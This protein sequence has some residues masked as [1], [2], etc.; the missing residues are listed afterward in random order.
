M[1]GS[2][3]TP[4]KVLIV[5][6]HPIVREAL[7][8]RLAKLRD[9]MVCAEAEDMTDAL[10]LIDVHNPDLAIVDISL[11]TS[12]GLDLIK[13]I[14]LRNGQVRMLVWSMHNELLYAER[15]LRAGALGYVTKEQA[16][17]QI[18][19]AIRQVLAGQVYLSKA[20]TERLLHR[21]VG[22]EGEKLAASPVQSLSDRELEIL[23]LISRGVKTTA[24][25]GQLHLSVKTIETYRD[26]IR[27]KLNLPD[28]YS[29]LRF[30]V[31]WDQSSE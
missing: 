14:K 8:L 15:S 6:D 21:V 16:T 5:D 20:M 30:A 18:I 9:L 4:A 2:K 11:K 17:D 23:R 12:D 10:K 7:A 22:M 29:L 25:A 24:I 26:R 3:K 19:Q 31:Q 27:R 1:P 28:S 13:R